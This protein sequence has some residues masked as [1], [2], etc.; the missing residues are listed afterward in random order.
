[1]EEIQN[2]LR[3]FVRIL[4][5]LI[6]LCFFLAFSFMIHAVTKDLK[7]RRRRFSTHAMY[8]ARLCCKTFRIRVKVTGDA[9]PERQGLV[10]SNHLG[11]ID[12]L[13]IASIRPNLF[14][15][16]KEMRETP[17]L[18]LITEMGGCIYVE[19]RSRSNILKELGEMVDALK[20]GFRVMLYPEATST[21]GEQV[22]PFKRTLLT[23]AAHAGVPIL[24]ISFNFLEINREPGFKM[25]YRDSVCWY[26][27][28]AFHTAIWRA[29][30]L[31][32]LTCEVK[33][34]A[35]VATRVDE[36]RGIVADSL[37]D[38]VAAN[39]TPPA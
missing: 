18:G 35:P 6:Y 34:L 11:F 7:T 9:S 3:S 30:G 10:V 31:H 25:K 23:A 28:M 12:I 38:M 2:G 22:L 24:P 8:W 36:D 32:S 4:I 27:D 37:H 13:A 15:T 33:F 29:F 39:Y 26:G 21:N 19:R 16:S 17:V 14:V 5:F 20:D 1:M